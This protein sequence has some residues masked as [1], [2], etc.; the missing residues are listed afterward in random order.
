MDAVKCEMIPREVFMK[1][2]VTLCVATAFSFSTLVGLVGSTGTQSGEQHLLAIAGC[3]EDPFVICECPNATASSRQ[4]SSLISKSNALFMS[5]LASE[6]CYWRE[7]YPA[8]HEAAVI[9][10]ETDVEGASL[11]IIRDEAANEVVKSLTYGS[12]AYIGLTRKDDGEFRWA[13]G[14]ALGYANWADGEPKAE[15]EKCVMINADG[16]GGWGVVNCTE[17]IDFVCSARHDETHDMGE[18]MLYVKS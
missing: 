15:D 11:V 10:C 12:P 2:A 1:P 6:F 14:G 8:G 5:S 18:H 4:S 3:P 9:S 13:D 7:L 17:T 16:N